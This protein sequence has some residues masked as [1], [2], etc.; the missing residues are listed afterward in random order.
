MKRVHSSERKPASTA[1]LPLLLLAALSLVLSPRLAAGPLTVYTDQLQNGFEDGSWGVHNMAQASVVHAGSAAISFEPNNWSGLS[2]S[3]TAGID[4]SRYGTLQFWIHGGTAGGQTLQVIALAGGNAIGEGAPLASFVPGG[5]I[6][7]G[8]WVQ[9]QVPF[10]ALGAASGTLSGFRIMDWTGNAQAAV[11]VDDIQINEVVTLPPLV[12]YADQLQNGFEDGSW[13]THNMAET[14]VV[15]SGTAAI[16]FEPSNWSGLSLGRAGGIDLSQY[17]AVQLWVH[18]G[19]AG[20]QKLRVIAVAGDP[21][22]DGASLETFLPGGKVPAG[23]WVQATVP[24]AS[25]GATSGSLTAFRI[26]DWTG[27]SQATVYFDDIQLTQRSTPLPPPPSGAPVTVA[28]DPSAN[29]R[30][31]SPLVYGVSGGSAAQLARLK[32]PSRRWGGNNTTRYNWQNDTLNSDFDWFYINYAQDNANPGALPD[33]SSADRFIDEARSAGVEPLITVPL[34]G[35]TPVDRVRRWGFSVAKYGAQQQTECTASGNASWCNPDAGNGKHPD[36]SNMTGND[37]RDTSREIGPSFV[38]DWMKHIAARTGTAGQGGVKFFALDNEPGIWFSTHRDV[39][40]LKAGYDEL[41]QRTRDYASAMKAQDPN[42][43]LFGPVPWGWCEYFFSYADGDCVDGPDRQAHG[44]LAWIP[45]YLKQVNDYRLQTGVRLVDY[46]DVH[47]YPYANNVGLSND[48]STATSALRLR[49]IKALYDPTYVDE[50]WVAQ[51]VNLIPRMKAWIDQYGP[52]TKLA[53]TEYSYGNDAGTSSVLAQAEVLAI[54]GREG[55]DLANRWGAPEDNTF[56][57]DAFKLYLNYDGT[58]SKA[59]SVS[60]KAVSSDVDAVGAYALADA[61]KVYVLLFNK[62]TATR[63]AHVSISGSAATSRRSTGSRPPPGSARPAPHRF[64]AVRSRSRSR[65]GRRPS[66]CW[67]GAPR[68]TAASSRSAAAPRPPAPRGASASASQT[69]RPR[70][71]PPSPRTSPTTPAPSRRPRS[72]LL[73]AGRRRRGASSPPAPTASRSPAG[74]ARS[75]TAPPRRSASRRSRGSAVL[76]RSGS[77]RALPPR[78]TAAP[79]R[80][81]SAARRAL[82]P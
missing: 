41:W 75:R 79:R 17:E 22:G 15:H 13:G 74:P 33:G 28:V 40:P 61:A 67:A 50:S 78:P 64:R 31:V 81:R 58:G 12:V 24:F 35:W 43:Q 34:I 32:F 26:M 20:G 56:M 38:T 57:E 62:D 30:N 1:P 44:G 53:I 76:S 46:L 47:A 72:P 25:L 80:S 5:K 29:R 45:W 73:S 18:G 42:A 23:S 7:A 16:S 48:E 71:L 6:P 65:R 68:R 39:H 70:T 2:L 19:T 27:A 8:S 11:Y 82:S 36:G 66:P 63:D 60:V 49:S 59:G 52:G 54:F 21:I 55:V 3:R 10:A 69:A 9:V 14:S 4:V 37:P 77:G 51:P